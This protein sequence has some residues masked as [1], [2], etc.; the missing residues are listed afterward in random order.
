[1][2]IRGART[3][4]GAVIALCVLSLSGSV[5]GQSSIDAVALTKR[6]SPSVVVV[7]S[8][9]GFGSGVVISPDGKIGTSLHVI[10]DADTLMVQASNG[11]KYAGVTVLAFDV[12]RDLA[13]LRVPGFDLPAAEMGNSGDVA[14]GEPVLLI[15]A[16]QGLT[17]TT[18]AGIVSALRDDP[19]G[20][21]FKVIQTDAASNPGNSGGPLLNSR[22]QVIGILQ[23]KLRG[24][25]NL[26]FAVPINYLRGLLGTAQSPMQLREFRARLLEDN[27]AVSLGSAAGGLPKVWKSLSST[28]RYD[29][30]LDGDF[31]YA[32]RIF[33]RMD[34]VERV[35]AGVQRPEDIFRKI[36][37]RKSGKLYAGK[38][39]YGGTCATGLGT[40]NSCAF[41]DQVEFTL[42]TPTR[43][44]GAILDRPADTKFDCR[45]CEFSKP[46]QIIKFTWIPE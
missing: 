15:G 40:S 33:S 11:E 34:L 29:V 25:Q 42:V 18:T 26:N 9:K 43:I 20:G 16:P 21:G 3:F 17:G 36:E 6:V 27:S 19:F 45:K 28:A 41:E 7:I 46:K 38:V 10:L 31:I 24:S 35:Y 1:V 30:R 4:R 44:E 12:V 14:V 23:S 13:I 32:E 39:R 22:G 2:D 5:H 37:A 8:D